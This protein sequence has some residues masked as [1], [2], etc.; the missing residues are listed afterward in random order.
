MAIVQGLQQQLT[1]QKE[2]IDQLQARVQ[3]LE[4]Q[5][6]QQK[7]RAAAAASHAEVSSPMAKVNAHIT[8]SGDLSDARKVTTERQTDVVLRSTNR[9]NSASAGT[10]HTKST[11]V[12]QPSTIALQPVDAKSAVSEPA[13]SP[14]VNPD[15]KRFHIGQATA[16]AKKHRTGASCVNP[17]T[18]AGHSP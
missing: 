4:D 15:R 9:A 1:Q 11:G 7:C 13:S 3:R 6:A 2:V 5:Q 17:S 8:I 14:V 10:A 12:A 16:A 18:S